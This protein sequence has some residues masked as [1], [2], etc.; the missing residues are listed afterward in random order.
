M[1]VG[2]CGQACHAEHARHALG[3]RHPLPRKMKGLEAVFKSWALSLTSDLEP[4]VDIRASSQ[5]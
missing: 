3:E 5:E 2:H 4:I 1:R